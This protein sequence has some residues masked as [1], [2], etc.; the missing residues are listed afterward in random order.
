MKRWKESIWISRVQR[1]WDVWLRWE[2]IFV[3]GFK[4]ILTFTIWPPFFQILHE[5]WRYKIWFSLNKELSSKELKISK[6]TTLVLTGDFNIPGT[7]LKWEHFSLA[8]NTTQLEQIGPEDSWNTWMITLWC[9][10]SGSW[11]DP[12]S[13]G[14]QQGGPCEQ[15]GDWCPSWPQWP[16]NDWD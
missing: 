7:S 12:W 15:R 11:I 1:H 10:Y 4:I 5:F 3:W 9:S 8:G 13:A 16:W 14:C 6:S 2:K